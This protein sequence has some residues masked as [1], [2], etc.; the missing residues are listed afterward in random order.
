MKVFE[1]YHISYLENQ[2]IAEEVLRINE[3]KYDY[4]HLLKN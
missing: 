4:L 3:E 1:N 2:G